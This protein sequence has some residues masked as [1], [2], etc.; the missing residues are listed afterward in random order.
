MLQR[1]CNRQV[2]VVQLDVFAD[3]RDL[4]MVAARGDALEH[5]DPVAHIALG[6]ADGQLAAHNIGQVALLEHHRRLIQHGKGAVLNNAVRLH[7]AEHGDLALDVVIHRLVDAGDDDVRGNTQAAQLL[8]RVLSGLGL[9]LVRAGDVR[10]QGHVDKQ[11]VAAADLGRHL[12]DGFEEGLG[13]NVAR[14]AA[15]LGD[16]HVCRSLFADRVDERLDLVG[17][18]RDDLH[19]F[20][21]V[22]TRALLVEHVPV[23]LARGQV[24]ELVQILVDEALVVAEVEVGLRAVV[25]H[26]YLAV[27][28]RAHRAGVN[29]DIGVELLRRHLE[30]AALEQAAERCSRNALA[31]TGDHATGHENVLCHISISP[32]NTVVAAPVMNTVSSV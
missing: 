19:G 26:V 23:H 14:G 31:Q 12:A 18:V 3:Q 28:E 27:L 30:A 8:D 11:A 21:Q 24:G 15:D 16:D 22:F 10:D 1:L 9:R 17:D 32:L 5:R 7:G 4:D 20:A 29:I 2:C 25:G 13:F 6:R